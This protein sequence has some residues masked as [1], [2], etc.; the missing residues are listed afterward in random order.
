MTR[1]CPA[2]AYQ[3]AD[4]A[5][6]GPAIVL[7]DGKGLRIVSSA[8]LAKRLGPSRGQNGIGPVSADRVV[9]VR[10]VRFIIVVRLIADGQL[11]QAGLGQGLGP[12][13]VR[14]GPVKDR[15]GGKEGLEAFV[16]LLPRLCRAELGRL[17]LQGARPRPGHGW[18]LG[19]HG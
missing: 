18:R 9:H 19:D 10:A 3:R 12:A 16:Q 2:W 7:Q 15:R 14:P 11:T 4:R 1:G 13:Q 5:G 17:T 6:R 8:P